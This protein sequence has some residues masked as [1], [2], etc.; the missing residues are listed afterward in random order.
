MNNTVDSDSASELDDQSKAWES[1][2]RSIQRIAQDISKQADCGIGHR[3]HASRSV[4]AL[5]LD[6]QCVFAGLQGGDIVVGTYR[7]TECSLRRQGLTEMPRP[8]HSILS[9]SSSPC[10]P[11]KRV[12]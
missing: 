9:R 8:G 3:V 11:T 7:M 2:P 4:L 5:V 10:M 1:D 6:D 12:S